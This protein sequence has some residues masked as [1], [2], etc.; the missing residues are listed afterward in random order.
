MRIHCT[1]FYGAGLDPIQHNMM[2]VCPVCKRFLREILVRAL[3]VM[4]L[5]K[6]T[7][8]YCY[9]NFTTSNLYHPSRAGKYHSHLS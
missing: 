6:S 1:D 4:C 7:N 3:G 9:A 8:V 5:D 2:W